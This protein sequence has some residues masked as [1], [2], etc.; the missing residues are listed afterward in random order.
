MSAAGPGPSPRVLLLRPD[1]LGDVILSLAALG[2]LRAALPAARITA[3]VTPSVAD[4]ARRCPAVDDVWTA[5]FPSPAAADRTATWDAA[6]AERAPRLHGRFDVALLPR[7]DDPWSGQ[8]ASAAD[9]PARFGYDHP[10]TRPYLTQALPVPGRRH[11]TRLALDLAGA[12]ADYCGTL[13][14]PPTEPSDTAWIAPTDTDRAEVDALARRRG[15]DTTRPYAIVHPGAGWPL[16]TWP[17][18]HWGAVA[19]GIAERHGLQ[20]LISGSTGDAALVA[21]VVE[22]SGGAASGLA[23]ALSLGGLA[24]LCRRATLVVANDSGPLHLAVAVGS[25]VVGLYGPADPTEF[26]PWCAP[27]RA[28]VVRLALPCSPCR[29]MHAPPCGA[30]TMPACLTEIGPERVVAAADELLA[31]SPR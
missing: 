9:I 19:R 14:A 23:G 22:A 17:A 20:A 5:P 24:E 25:P 15:I 12:V 13:A 10:R 1:H 11:V 3:L 7:C 4:V 16:K 18:E 31:P 6:V 26:G 30:V 28:R 29:T 21:A 27:R 8:L 2:W